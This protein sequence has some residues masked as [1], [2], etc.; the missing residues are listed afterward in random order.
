MRLLLVAVFATISF[1]AGAAA[2]TPPQNPGAI[3][4]TPMGQ[5]FRAAPE[6]ATAPVLL[7]L[8]HADTD[9]DQKIS[10][11]E[12][13]TEAMAFFTGALDANSD[14]AVT[15]VESTAFWRAEAPELLNMRSAAPATT[16]QQRRR[17]NRGSGAR[18]ALDADS[19]QPGSPRTAPQRARGRADASNPYAEIMLGVAAEPVM[20]CDRDFS[21]RIDVTEFQA[22]AERRFFELDANRDGHFS[23]DES[24]QA[25]AMLAAYAEQEAP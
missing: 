20:S 12:F 14:G 13:V 9:Q 15:S 1:A 24:E 19:S 25:Q 11:D 6:S 2:Q 17:D 4:I 5:P 22:C 18:G 23:L 8:A 10:R 21:R 3:F 7:W 16:P